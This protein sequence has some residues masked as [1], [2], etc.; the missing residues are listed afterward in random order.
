MKI[1]RGLVFVLC[2]CCTCSAV[3]AD[4]PLNA[5]LNPTSDNWDDPS[6]WSLGVLP[7]SSQSVLITNSGWKAVAINPSTP[8]SFPDSMT[9]NNLTIRGAWD[10]ENVLLL[11]Y[12][13]TAVPL[14]VLNGLTLQDNAQLL[15]FDSGLIVRGGTIMVT[16]SQIM[17]DG[18]IIRTTNSPM[19][20]QN[21]Q[22]QLTNGVFEGGQV[23]L[24]FP[25]SASFNQYGGTAMISDLQFGRGPSLGAG[26]NYALYGGY[27]TLPN[28][29]LLIGDGNSSSS[30]FQAGGS[31]QTT[32]VNIEG[33]TLFQLNGGLLADNAVLIV[34]ADHAGSATLEQN[35][36]THV[37][38]NTLRIEGGAANGYT[39]LPATC[40]LNGGTLSAGVIELDAD[41]GDSVFVQSNGTAS[42]GT[43]YAHSVGFYGSHNTVVTLAGGTLSCS[44]YTT[45]DGGGTLTQSGGVLVVSNLLDLGGFRD[46]GPGYSVYGRYT[47]TG[48]SLT[49]SNINITGDWII[50]DGST[51]RIS[52]PG[53]FSLWHDLVISNA[54]EQLGRF[55][56]ATNATIDLAGSASRLSFANSRGQAWA[57][58]ATLLVADW[59]GQPSG[60]GPEQLKFGTDQSGLTPAQVSQLRFS[61][62]T[63][64]YLAKI[65][66]TGE[67]VPDQG[68]STSGLVNSWINPGS[69]NWDQPTNWSLGVIPDS[70]QAVMITNSGWKAVAINA[71]TPTNFPGSMTVS[72]LAIRG[73]TNT[74]NVLLLDYFGSDVPLTVLSGVTLQDDG[75]IV[76][77]NSGL[78]VQGGTFLV[79]NTTMI[80]DGGF[81]SATNGPMTLSNSEYDMTNGVFEGGTVALGYP[82]P[83]H[84][85]QYGGIVEISNLGLSSYVPSSSSWNGYALYGGTLH[86]P[87]GMS[88]VGEAGG[89]SYFQSGGTNRTTQVT[90]EPDYGGYV[91]GFTLNG[92]L[93]ADSG[94]ELRAGYETPMSMEQNGGSHEITNT[95][96]I[97][98]YDT[99]GYASDPATYYLNG[100]TLS[101]GVLELDANGGDS[102]FVQS[103]A[104]TFAGTVYAHSDGYYLSHNTFITL[105]SGTLSCSN[106][107]TDDGQ[108]TFNQSGG[109]L[110]VSSLLDFGGSRN[111]GGPTTYYGRYTFTGGTVT[112]S[113]INITDWIIGDGSANRISN[114]GFFRLSHMLQISNA[115]EHLGRFILAGDATI[116]LA[117]SASRLSFANSSGENWAAGALLLVSD[118]NGILSGGGA[119][120]LK[121]GPDQSG[122][123]QAQLNQSYFRIGTNLY[124]AKIL[125]TGEVVPDQVV[126]PPLAVSKQGNQLVLSWLPG[127]SLQTATNIS[128]PYVNVPGT[129]PSSGASSPYTNDMTLDPQRF[130]RLAP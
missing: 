117:G 62:G 29:L 41:Q 59:N 57:A 80:Q 121:F 109:A 75:R 3:F 74:E 60:G 130:F 4:T 23:F 87:G 31:N 105:A 1:S 48:G 44:N 86:L 120:Q 7:S 18:G 78:V 81:V 95:L 71:S 72:N 103:N 124:S 125:N 82:Y 51:T 108:A 73:A 22:Y 100:G 13:G 27:L 99:H 15:S 112:A 20:L 33:R 116:D 85:N 10:T 68:S 110:V 88:L 102:V 21:S 6:A 40:S 16:N 25:V 52:N 67:V 93:L 98:G 46:L 34:S 5:W 63:N 30:Y 50:G 19:Y 107:T 92:G 115:V 56:L 14:T 113:N 66:S 54:V 64:L 77:F 91:G 79:T 119:E 97:A 38:T 90:V 58:G 89:V 37:V 94:V 43:V 118:W 123:T 129:G 32:Q 8:V 83:A 36:G 17:Q 122:L 11:N 128:G 35:G 84:F 26:G 45:V 55:I 106:Y 2:C 114:P 76:N 70:S 12:F 9:V 42:T 96:Y 101:V 28:G 111:V 53:Y 61:I 47:F 24:G 49:A 126:P 39:V 65:L 104:S 69:A 127:Y